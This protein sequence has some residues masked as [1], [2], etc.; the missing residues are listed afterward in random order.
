MDRPFVIR[1]KNE[2][3]RWRVKSQMLLAPFGGGREAFCRNPSLLF[4]ERVEMRRLS[5]RSGESRIPSHVAPRLTRYGPIQ[6]AYA[7]SF[8]SSPL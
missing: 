1:D 6:F 7:S 8:F 4:A 2:R 3:L 5:S